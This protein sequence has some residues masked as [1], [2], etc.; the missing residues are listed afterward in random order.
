MKWF[1]VICAVGFLVA[2]MVFGYLGDTNLL[3]F[4]FW[5]CIA[6]L[7]TANLDRISQFKASADGIEAHTRDVVARAEIAVSELQLLA[8]HVAE[9][10]LSLV[11]RQGRW[12]GYN[13]EEQ[14]RIRSSVLDVLTKL[15]IPQNKT[16]HV[17]DEWHRIVEFDY[18]HHILGGTRIP[19]NVPPDVLTEWKKLRD[20][21]FAA[22]PSTQ[23][24]RDF[25]NKNQYMTAELG[26]YLKDYE[27]YSQ[28]R[29]HRRPSAWKVRDQWGH[30]EP[31]PT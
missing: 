18:T 17:L 29:T 11:K 4:G 22:Y 19:S 5:G 8:V 12:G 21:G 9:L 15:S 2:G 25:L 13:D 31:Q 27:H 23:E 24:L 14:D 7:V 3:S 20:G 1:L 26:E 30:L 6:F 28:N 10:S 16:Q